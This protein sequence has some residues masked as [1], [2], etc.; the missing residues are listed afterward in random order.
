[1]GHYYNVT[2]YAIVLYDINH[3]IDGSGLYCS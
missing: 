2:L 1:L 3:L